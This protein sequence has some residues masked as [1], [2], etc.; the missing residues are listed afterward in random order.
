[1]SHRTRDDAGQPL[2]EPKRRKRKK[3][4][5]LIGSSKHRD[6]YHLMMQEGWSSTSLSFYADHRFGETISP[7]T[8]RSYRSRKGWPARKNPANIRDRQ[9]ERL[10]AGYDPEADHDLPIDVFHE[11]AELARLQRL[12]VALAVNKEVRTGELEPST[13][14][15][16]QT[17]S[18][19]LSE[20]SDDMRVMGLLPTAADDGGQDVGQV[21]DAP[22]GTERQVAPAWSNQSLGEAAGGMTPED[23]IAFARTLQE[24]GLLGPGT[25]SGNGHGNGMV[26]DG[27]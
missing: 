5:N 7:S 4:A 14:L 3:P 15:E 8:F 27:G 17:L 25:V 18:K 1:M 19:L 9:N 12:R 22:G 13:R 6:V 16:I 11:R 24:F 20:I 21:R 2:P 23:E 10:P 26:V